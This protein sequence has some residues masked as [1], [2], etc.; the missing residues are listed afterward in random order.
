LGGEHPQ[1]HRCDA[2]QMEQ[3]EAR[4]AVPNRLRCGSQ[5]ERVRADH[6]LVRAR[7]NPLPN[8]G[9]QLRRILSLLRSALPPI[10]RVAVLITV[11]VASAG[12]SFRSKALRRSLSSSSPPSPASPASATTAAVTGRR[13]RRARSSRISV[14]APAARAKFR[15]LRSHLVLVVLTT[16]AAATAPPAPATT[17]ATAAASRIAAAAVAAAVPRLAR[18]RSWRGHNGCQVEGLWFIFSLDLGL[19]SR[20]SLLSLSRVSV[21]ETPTPKNEGFLAFS[22]REKFERP[23]GDSRRVA[24]PATPSAADVSVSPFFS[25]S[26]SVAYQQHQ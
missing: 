26:R 13:C 7:L 20:L 1:T 18:R 3:H 8:V 4:V 2:V 17:A 12:V 9:C 21:S 5:L 23:D 10:F 6:A 22:F 15:R 24:A 11:A 16:T 14:L 25:F 19:F